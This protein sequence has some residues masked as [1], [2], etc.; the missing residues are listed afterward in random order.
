MEQQEIKRKNPM[1]DWLDWLE[2]IALA[3]ITVVLLFSFFFRV[4]GVKG[5]SMERTLFENDRLIV[6]E[7]FYTPKAGDIVILNKPN[8]S[9]KPF[10]KRVIA[11]GGQKVDIDFDTGEVYV[12]DQLIEEPYLGSGI[13]AKADDQAFPVYLE[14]NEIFVMGDNRAHST[15]S[16]ST[17]IGTV[18]T[19]Y[20]VGKV[21][22]RIFPL[23]EFGTLQ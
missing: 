16:R 22:L 19:R 1:E 9:G 13:S 7:A 14:E 23:E 8:F 11:T 15:D 3:V 10:V 12:D 20:V 2:S 17:E 5:E 21:V 6:Q 18:D 4:V